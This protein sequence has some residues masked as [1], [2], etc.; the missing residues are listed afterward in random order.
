MAEAF[1]TRNNGS[2]KGAVSQIFH[3]GENPPEETKLF[4]IDTNATTGG[5]KYY[6]GTKWVVVPVAYF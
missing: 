5:L 6:N 3:V 1:I 2:S 4:W